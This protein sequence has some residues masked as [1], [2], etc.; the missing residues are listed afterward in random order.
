MSLTAKLV[1][2]VVFSLTASIISNIFIPDTTTRT[3]IQSLILVI[4]AIAFYIFIAPVFGLIRKSHQLLPDQKSKDLDSIAALINSYT[5]TDQDLESKLKNLQNIYL[6][7]QSNY[8]SILDSLYD[9]VIA[10]DRFGKVAIANSAITKMTGYSPSELTGQTPE[11]FFQV[12][13]R[14]GQAIPLSE[15]YKSAS[16]QINFDENM[17]FINIIG[18]HDQKTKAQIYSSATPNT[19]KSGIKSIIIFRDVG[20][21][22]DYSSIQLDFVSMASH[23]LRTPLTSII[24]YL[25]VFMDENKKMFNQDQTEFLNRIMISAKQL[26]SLIENLLN[27]SKVERNAFSINAVAVDW[28]TFLSKAVEDNRINAANKNISL[29]LKLP[30]QLPKVNADPIR[31][32]EVVNNLI[33]NAISYTKEGGHIEVGATVNNNE[34]TTYVRDNGMGIPK[35]AQAHLFTKFFRVKGALDQSSNSK[36]TGLGLYLTKSIVDLHHGRIWVES[37][38]GKGSTFCFTLHASEVIKPTF[39][40]PELTI[41]G[42]LPSVSGSNTPD[43]TLPNQIIGNPHP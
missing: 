13:D 40:L 5:K 11:H 26:A 21:Q 27:V 41:P 9:A 10:I 15:I 25:S 6:Y 1:L 35:H 43:S 2:S 31:I 22:S 24:G 36:G 20:K 34:V 16:A 3:L 33:S 28:N 12:Q 42:T 37:E 4:E 23:E 39:N 14:N 17:P 30:P 7:T 32:L 18:R 38:P 8:T 29:A 19:N